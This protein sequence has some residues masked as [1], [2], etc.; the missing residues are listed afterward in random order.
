MLN[1]TRL[2][3]HLKKIL[4]K[5]EVDRA[6]FF[7]VLA[8]IWSVGAGPVTALVIVLKFTPELQG[9]YYTFAA[10]IAFQFVLELGLSSVII[11]FASHEWSKLSL[12]KTGHITGDQQA[13]S[14]LQSLARFTFYW[15][16]GAA[17]I[18]TIG[19]AIGGY[20][21]FSRD[22]STVIDWRLSWLA[23]CCLNGVIFFL[24]PI[25]ALL[26]GCNQV[27][28]VYTYRFTQGICGS[29]FVWIAMLSGAGLW[30][31]SISRLAILVWAVIFLKRNYW[32][33]VRSLFFVRAK[34]DS[35][36]LWFQEIWPMQRRIS[37]SSFFG[38]F[39]MVLFT[40]VLFHYHGPVIAGQMGM[41]WSLIA[42]LGSISSSWVL[43]KVPRFG[44]LI[45]K[46]KYEE[47]DKLFWRIT[48]ITVAIIVFLSVSL[49]LLIYFLNKGQYSLAMRVLSP[50]PTGIF[51]IAQVLQH[52]ALPF[53]CYLR[54]H[55]REPLLYP[56]ILQGI[57][58][59]LST[60]IL[61]KYF[62]AM[63]MAVGCLLVN[64][65]LIPTS[66]II[67]YRCRIDW[68]EVLA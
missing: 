48:K 17:I 33:F 29:V 11:Q 2:K 15:Y 47:L 63:G 28:N 37:I 34:S 62:S 46:K 40:P 58:I 3:H 59:A 57:F 30:T 49:W 7:N 13:L 18:L 66:L 20:F 14:R 44:I 64:M 60:L 51:L 9:Y 45:A 19:L 21:F 6:V 32:N 24:V 4:H 68:H 35:R 1:R 5:T 10:I 55:K 43:P 36:I 39:A 56:S 22:M 31:A 41:T 38:S 67:W 27:S 25:W 65:V 52:G 42:A 50:L 8:K 61:G 12:D 26:E 16:L 23:L 53:A 54:A